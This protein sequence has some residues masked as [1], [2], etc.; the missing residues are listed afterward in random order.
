MSEP[1]TRQEQISYAV[2]HSKTPPPEWDR[3]WLALIDFAKAVHSDPGTGVLT[4]FSNYF[5]RYTD[6]S[7][8]V[9]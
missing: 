6:A 3:V 8:S 1:W 4:V 9:D 7:I 2:F 5:E